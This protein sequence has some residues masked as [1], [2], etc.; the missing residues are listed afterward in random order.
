MNDR[1]SPPTILIEETD[2]MEFIRLE[3]VRDRLRK[4]AKVHGKEHVV[5]EDNLDNSL[6]VEAPPQHPDLDTPKFSGDPD[7]TPDPASLPADMRRDYDNAQRE[8]QLQKQNR[9]QNQLGNTPQNSSTPK[10]RGP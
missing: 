1:D 9:L 3:E 2:A 4:M 5:Q 8:Q 6:N 10:P 7:T